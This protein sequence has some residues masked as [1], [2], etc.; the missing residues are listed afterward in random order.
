MQYVRLVLVGLRFQ[1]KMLSRSSFNGILGILYPLFFATVAFFMYRA[2]AKD[3]LPYASLGAAVMGIWSST[4]TSAGSAMQRERWHGTLELL[5][6]APSPFS[7]VMLPTTIAMSFLGLYSMAATLF[8]GRVAFGIHVQVAHWLP[9]CIGIAV[10]V[11]SIGMCG[12]LMAVAF[13]RYRAA[14]ALGNLFEYPV[15]LTCGFLVS[16]DEFHSHTVRVIAWALAPY[17]GMNG[18]RQAASGATDGI[19]DTPW[20]DIGMCAALGLVYLAIGMAVSDYMLRA[21][22]KNATLALT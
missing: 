9:F 19:P 15:W 20:P 13:V 2:G 18:I 4:S 3:A 22:R 14:W 16:I 17:W 1:V 5:V 21:A 12:F 6:A 7:L 11:V 8:W 10:T